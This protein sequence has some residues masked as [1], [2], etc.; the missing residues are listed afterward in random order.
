MIDALS[1][2]VCVKQQLL[3]S[4]LE[5]ILNSAVEI[6]S[7][8]PVSGGDIN[9]AFKIE[10]N[11][12]K[13]FLKKN[14]TRF[15]GMFQ[16]EYNGLRAIA[17]ADIHVPEPFACGEDGNDQ[18]LIMEWIERGTPA[19]DFWQKFAAGLSSLHRNT[20]ETFG[21]YEA[22]YIGSLQQMNDCVL[23]WKEF[24]ATQRIL[25]LLLMG[26]QLG[27][28]S[29]SDIESG[30]M[31][32]KKINEIFPEEAPALLHGDLW[33]GNYMI[34]A[35]GNAVLIDPAVY[36]GHR[37]M[38]IGMSL[39]FGGFDE[40]FYQ[41]YNDQ[42][43]LAPGWRERVELCQLYPLLVHMILFG[44]HYYNSVQKILRRYE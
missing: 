6:S 9:E 42:F 19:R 40:S 36:Y 15:K 30:V 4:A 38:D 3:R 39:L 10:T 44:G 1:T 33:S 20:S 37:E 41:H 31:V 29:K 18:W 21:F 35:D 8:S 16:K 25:P 34:N 28:C 13:F 26:A 24:F 17:A 11:R 12:G 7:I 43:P 27:R 2:F 5:A 22:N 23:S 14:S 32:C